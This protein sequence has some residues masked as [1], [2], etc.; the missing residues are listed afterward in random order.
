MQLR[1]TAMNRIGVLQNDL[2]RQQPIFEMNRTTLPN[3]LD[4]YLPKHFWLRKN[5]RDAISMRLSMMM[6]NRV[7]VGIV[8]HILYQCYNR[9]TSLEIICCC[10][11]RVFQP[12]LRCVDSVRSP[13]ETITH[14]A[15]TH[16]KGS[17][18]CLTTTRCICNSWPRYSILVVSWTF[19][20]LQSDSFSAFR[21]SSTHY[22]I[23]S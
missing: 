21:R 20:L 22:K 2:N 1:Q 14:S 12:R 15:S 18:I 4:F 23:E 17:A 5:D 19:A 6:A 9:R 10:F 13:I 7:K 16:R 3:A 11:I 8:K